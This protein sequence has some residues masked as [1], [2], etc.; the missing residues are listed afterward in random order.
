MRTPRRLLAKNSIRGFDT[1]QPSFVTRTYVPSS[2]FLSAVRN[3]PSCHVFR[4]FYLAC[5]RHSSSLISG[6]H[7]STGS[8]NVT[9]VGRGEQSLTSLTMLRIDIGATL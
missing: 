2:L 8:Q 9:R 6:G 4:G 1:R 7:Q 3:G 5:L